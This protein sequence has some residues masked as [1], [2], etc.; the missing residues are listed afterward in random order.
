MA[1]KK[2]SYKVDYLSAVKDAMLHLA[3][4]AAAVG[5]HEDYVRAVHSII[6]HLQTRPFEWGDP[7]RKTRKEGGM[8][9]HGLLRP[10][11]YV[12]YV[13]FEPDRVVCILKF[14]PLPK[15]PLA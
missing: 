6:E 1:E 4:R 10:L 14:T 2:P 5:I 3:A 11:L 8:V 9:Y 12:Q 13:V 7:E 15:S